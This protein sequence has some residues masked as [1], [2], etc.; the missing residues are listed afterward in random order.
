[1]A[2]LLARWCDEAWQV[3]ALVI[4][5]T[6]INIFRTLPNFMSL[7]ISYNYNILEMLIV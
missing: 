7:C 1:M 3:R 2:E 4:I 5:G 6:Y